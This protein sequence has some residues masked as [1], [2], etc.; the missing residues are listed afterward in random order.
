MKVGVVGAGV[1]G[2]GVAQCFATSGHEVVVVD[3]D[4]AALASGPSRVRDG[5]R[6]RALLGGAR[7]DPAEVGARLR[8]TAGLAELAGCGFVVECAPERVS[9]KRELFAALGGVC[10][11]EAVL[12]SCTSAIPVAVLAA[13]TAVPERVLA[14]H[15]MNPAPLKDAVEVVRGAG[16][17][18]VALARAVEVLA[19]L[20]K[21]AVVVG[22]APGFV[23][24]RVLMLTINEAV[25]VVAEG[26]AGAATVDEVFE[27]CFA[28]PMGPL[29][30]A[31]LIGL[32]T[33]RDTLLVLRDLLPD[34]ACEPSPLLTEMVEAGR[35]GRKTGQGFHTWRR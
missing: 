16:T 19:S 23:T 25:K 11:A 34:P 26:T 5:V 29:R 10:G 28:H 1:M 20:G 6:Q 30:T 3:P 14:T 9:V 4:P 33:V 2:T 7:V 35:L 12:A 17:S 27:S 18:E 13:V 15:F 24:N 31:D 8:W 32:D 21:K 22:D